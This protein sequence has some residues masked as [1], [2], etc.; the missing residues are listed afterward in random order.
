MLQFPER[1]PV[2]RFQKP[3]PAASQRRVRPVAD[4]VAVCAGMHGGK[5]AILA[6]TSR[7]IFFAWLPPGE[8]RKRPAD[9]ET[10]D[11]PIADVMSVEEQV[12]GRSAD[13]TVLTAHAAVSL[14]DVSRTR[15]WE[16]CRR[17]RQ[18]ILEDARRRQASRRTV[19][20]S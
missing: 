14:N 4:D 3:K 19:R 8:S 6:V 1:A 12:H 11:F 5:P 13:L 20:E 17:A 16:F 2:P 18:A 15:A 7:R 9:P 10:R